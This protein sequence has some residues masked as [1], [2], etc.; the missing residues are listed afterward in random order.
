M[1]DAITDSKRLAEF[2]NLDSDHAANHF[3]QK[4]PQFVPDFW[5]AELSFQEAPVPTPLWKVAQGFLQRAWKEKFSLKLCIWLL[6]F[7]QVHLPGKPFH[8]D[9]RTWSYQEA[10]MFLGT[11]HWRAK[12]C[13][14]C[15]TRFVADTPQNTY[16]SD[17]CFQLARKDSK[18]AWWSEHGHQWR[19]SKQSKK[20]RSKV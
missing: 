18:R 13:L 10:V 9:I 1:K 12:F 15:G 5:W 8:N 19:K 2:S 3:R 7:G 14:R 16:C 20:N 17:A 6:N 11:N 4:H